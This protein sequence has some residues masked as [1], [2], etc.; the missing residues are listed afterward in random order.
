MDQ[1]F[2]PV[3]GAMQ[4]SFRATLGV[5]SDEELGDSVT[6]QNTETFNPKM[7]SRIWLIQLRTTKIFKLNNLFKHIN[8]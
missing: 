4:G 3:R 5:A 2:L 7:I 8:K 1:T 6:R